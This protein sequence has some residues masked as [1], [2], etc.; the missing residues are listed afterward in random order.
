[1]SRTSRAIFGF[2]VTLFFSCT[3]RV[4]SPPQSAASILG[5]LTNYH[6]VFTNGSRGCQLARGDCGFVGDVAVNGISASERTSGTV[7]YAGTIYTNAATLG[8]WQDIVDDNVGQA[9]GATGEV[10]RCSG[11]QDRST[12]LF[13]KST[14]C[15]PVPASPA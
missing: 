4:H 1:M 14:R 10:T 15:R 5:N 2:T 9:F 7:P 11:L 12:A 6:L 3:L 13:L 8:A